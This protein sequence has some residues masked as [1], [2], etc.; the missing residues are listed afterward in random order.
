MGRKVALV[1]TVLTA[2]LVV[3][4]CSKKESPKPV[5]TSAVPATSASPSA[6]A[7]PTFPTTGPDIKPGE[8][9]PTL[10]SET[11]ANAPENAADFVLYYVAAIDWA[12][13]SMD[14]QAIQKLSL[15][16]CKTC[17]GNIVDELVKD[18]GAGLHWAGTKTKVTAIAVDA[19]AGAND[20]T[21]VMRANLVRAPEQLLTA[22]NSVVRNVTNTSGIYQF[23]LKWLSGH[24][25]MSEIR[26]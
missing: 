21:I 2:V 3:A 7:L 20:A 18:Q 5:V 10:S 13:K 6:A 26:H 11:Q 4:A 17:A 1:A 25:M 24:W 15:S 22:S 9:P 16:E 19:S 8:T 23:F 12:Y 14:P